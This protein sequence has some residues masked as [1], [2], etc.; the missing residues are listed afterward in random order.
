MRTRRQPP[1]LGFPILVRVVLGRRSVGLRQ[2]EVADPTVAFQQLPELVNVHVLVR[3]IPRIQHLLRIKQQIVMPNLG[4]AK[5]R[6][7]PPLDARLRLQ[8]L[9]EASGLQCSGDL[10]CP[11][12]FRARFT[13]VGFALIVRET[14]Q[15]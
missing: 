5:R 7:G 14:S 3:N 6:E 13:E 4:A 11:R 2:R 8:A 9:Y 12:R 15:L 10:Q 1:R